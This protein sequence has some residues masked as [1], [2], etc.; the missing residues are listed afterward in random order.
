MAG[1]APKGPC[2][3]APLGWPIGTCTIAL[4]CG[5]DA[6]LPAAAAATFSVRPQLVQGN[7]MLPVAGPVVVDIYKSEVRSRRSE[8]DQLIF[9]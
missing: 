4:H 8:R 1:G 3:G 2:C 6:R 7:S 9:S 5:H